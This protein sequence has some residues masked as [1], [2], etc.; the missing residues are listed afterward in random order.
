M[1]K[2]PTFE[3]LQRERAR[4]AGRPG[5]VQEPKMQRKL[6]EREILHIDAF[7]TLHYFRAQLE[8][9]QPIDPERLPDQFL[10]ALKNNCVGSAMPIVD[11]RSHYHAS[12]VLK[13]II[14]LS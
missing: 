4:R 1:S 6:T 14:E 5:Q 12:D 13:L 8:A 2:R 3:D 11:G 10:E 9:G 7:V